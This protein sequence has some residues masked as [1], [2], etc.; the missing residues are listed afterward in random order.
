MSLSAVSSSSPLM[1]LRQYFKENQEERELGCVTQLSEKIKATIACF[2]VFGTENE[3]LGYFLNKVFKLLKPDELYSQKYIGRISGV[4]CSTIRIESSQAKQSIQ[5]L[6]KGRHYRGAL[7]L[8][9]ANHEEQPELL[10]GFLARAIKKDKEDGIMSL[11]VKY[12]LLSIENRT[13]PS[14]QSFN[15]LANV[16]L[17]HP[18]LYKG[19]IKNIFEAILSLNLDVSF[20]KRLIN[21]FMD[22]LSRGMNQGLVSTCYKLA[23]EEGVEF[24]GRVKRLVEGW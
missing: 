17:D 16:L 9:P 4:I 7:H 10:E 20:R 23:L 11:S 13:I 18:H 24:P 3:P 6:E 21:K 15:T 5:Y 8:A 14:E 19:E 12:F 1:E 22:G 2:Q